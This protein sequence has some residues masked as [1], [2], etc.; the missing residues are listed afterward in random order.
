[1]IGAVA[2]AAAF[3][4]VTVLLAAAGGLVYLA[5]PSVARPVADPEDA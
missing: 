4:V 3:L 2:L 1:V 5:T